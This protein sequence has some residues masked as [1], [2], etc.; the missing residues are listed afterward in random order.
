M[1]DSE[2]LCA[3]EPHLGL[4]RFCLERG[5]NLGPLDQLVG[6]HLT[7]RATGVGVHDYES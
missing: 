3:M 2:R 1:H 5:S 7:H 6:Q 4:R